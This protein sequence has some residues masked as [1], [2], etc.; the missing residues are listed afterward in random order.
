MVFAQWTIGNDI[1]TP[2]LG[3]PTSDPTGFKTIPL[4]QTGQEYAKGINQ[5]DFRLTKKLQLQGQKSVRINADIYNALNASWVT[6]QN[7]TFGTGTAVPAA[8]W[9]R[10][11]GVVNGRMF[12]LG[13]QIDF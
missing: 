8:T 10:P 9:L 7:N 3:R 4:L 5:V 11:T 1:I 12:K 13:A 2:A 6:A